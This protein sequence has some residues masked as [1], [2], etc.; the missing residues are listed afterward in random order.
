MQD[1]RVTVR[2]A[3]QVL[4]VSEG[5]IRK[6]IDRGTLAHVRDA[7]GRIYVRLPDVED[8]SSTPSNTPESSALISELKDRIRSLEEANRENR[9]IIAGL[10]E[11]IPELE[12]A[13]DERESPVST[14]GGEGG[15]GG[16]PPA[17]DTDKPRASWWSRLFGA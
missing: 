13:P 12:A 6:R 16:D 9:R 4:G 5:A 8:A 17:N 15:S 1:G 2:Q 7:D 14:S 10:I 11:R 3:A